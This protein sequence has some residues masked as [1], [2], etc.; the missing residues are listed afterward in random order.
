[1]SLLRV[2][3]VCGPVLIE[4]MNV[5]RVNYVSLWMCSVIGHEFVE[6]YVCLW[7]CSDRGPEFAE[8]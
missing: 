1:M 5:L 8:I 7:T 6:S 4:G 2:M 3:Y